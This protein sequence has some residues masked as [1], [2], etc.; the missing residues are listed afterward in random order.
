NETRKRL[1]RTPGM[2][3]VVLDLSTQG[4]T[5]SR[6]FPV[7]FAVQGPDWETVTR[8]SERIKERMTDERQ[9]DG[10][11]FLTDVNSDYRPGMPEVHLIPD[12]EKAAKVGVSMQ[13][14]AWTLNVAFGGVRSGRFTDG[15]KR[16]DVRVRSFEQQRASP[17]ML[18]GLYVKTDDGELVPLC[19][20]CEVKIVSTLP[21]INRYNHLRKVELTAAM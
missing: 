3:P 7:N 20:L 19:D 11:P 10:R 2:R 17:D 18:K 6:G 1:G 15:D 16:Y 9:E 8:L 5:P 12:R 13:R 14:L 21:L 4:F